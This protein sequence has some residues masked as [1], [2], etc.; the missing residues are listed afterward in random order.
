MRLFNRFKKPEMN[1]ITKKSNEQM[2]AIL[3]HLESKH[4]GQWTKE[5]DI[6]NHFKETI[7]GFIVTT[8]LQ[9]MFNEEILDYSRNMCEYKLSTNGRAFLTNGGYK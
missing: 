3:K 2:N 5:S 4:I 7:P 6:E 9:R 8:G 1:E